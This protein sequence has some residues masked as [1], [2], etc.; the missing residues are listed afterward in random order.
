MNHY[1]V[2]IKIKEGKLIYTENKVMEDMDRNKGGIPQGDA[3][4]QRISGWEGYFTR[5]KK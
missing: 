5:E 2:I 3:S 1:K 4:R